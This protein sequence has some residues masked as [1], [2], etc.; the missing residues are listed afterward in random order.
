MNIL[1][2][3]NI[4]GRSFVA[5]VCKKINPVFYALCITFFLFIS[6]SV[7]SHPHSWI[8]LKTVIEGD[9][10]Q[11]TG[12]KMSWTFDAIT[13]SYMLDG[14][15]LSEQNK[16]KAL[17]EMAEGILENLV[18]TDY[19]TYFYNDGTPLKYSLATDVGIVQDRTKLTLNY[20]LPL[21]QPKLINGETV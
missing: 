17:Q 10:N 11:I 6:S 9:K 4:N 3:N 18:Q 5:F 16:A 21:S 13:S 2:K 14:E 20:F 19:F 12:F 15:D 7:Q 1:L 8:D